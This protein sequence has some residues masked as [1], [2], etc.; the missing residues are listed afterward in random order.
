MN[1]RHDNHPTGNTTH[2]VLRSS[3]PDKPPTYTYCGKKLAKLVKCCVRSVEAAD[4]PNCIK[5]QQAGK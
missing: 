3:D 4:C 5:M 1:R 2:I